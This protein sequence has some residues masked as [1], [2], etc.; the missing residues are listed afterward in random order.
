L[1][2]YKNPKKRHVLR[3]VY[4]H[5]GAKWA[6]S[7]P[8]LTASTSGSNTGSSWCGATWGTTTCSIVST[9]T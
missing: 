1:P 4:G 9:G 3:D 6:T 7:E 8:T 2:A 5:K